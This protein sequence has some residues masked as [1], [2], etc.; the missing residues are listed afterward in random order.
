MVGG[1]GGPGGGKVLKTGQGGSSGG[2]GGSS[3]GQGGP[4]VA[5]V[6]PVVPSGGQKKHIISGI[7]VIFPG[8]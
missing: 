5:R 4:V 1:P 6:G 3:G 2:Q 8:F 7:L